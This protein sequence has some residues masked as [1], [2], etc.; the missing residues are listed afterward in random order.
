VSHATQVCEEFIVARS[1]QVA[2]VPPQKSFHIQSVLSLLSLA[3]ELR[4]ERVAQ[5]CAARLASRS[6]GPAVDLLTPEWVK[7]SS[8]EAAQAVLLALMASRAAETAAGK[9]SSDDSS[10]SSDSDDE[11]D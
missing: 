9:G 4:L 11:D 8:R 5:M 3:A 7:G 10:D 2:R 6:L 1:T